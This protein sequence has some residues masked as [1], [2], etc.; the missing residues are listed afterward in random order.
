MSVRTPQQKRSRKTL[1]RIVD[2]GVA[3]LREKGPEGLTVQEVVARARTSVGSFYQRFSG[4]EELLRHLEGTLAIEQ[5][6][7]FEERLGSRISAE[8]ALPGRIDA[9]IALLLREPTV[10]AEED[11][12]RAEVAVAA[13]L[14]RRLEIRHPDPETAIRVGFAAVSGALREPPPGVDATRLVQELSRLWLWYLRA[15]DA[16]PAPDFFEV[17]G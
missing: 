14:E 13:F 12:A 4:R 15:G 16:A 10:T 3:I 9:I 17:W 5:R 7:R 2:A 6:S 1:A 8:L 11:A